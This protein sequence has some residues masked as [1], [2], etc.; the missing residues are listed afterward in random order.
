[1]WRSE[2][3][4]SPLNATLT[5]LEDHLPVVASI[6]MFR[7]ENKPPRQAPR[8]VWNLQALKSKRKSSK[9]L[10]ERDEKLSAFT[11]HK[12]ARTKRSSILLSVR[13]KRWTC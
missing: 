8:A 2:Y 6:R 10:A 3:E 12:T 5:G 13:K 7:K 9:F 4:A 1:M 11:K